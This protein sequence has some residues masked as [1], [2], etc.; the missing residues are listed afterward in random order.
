M[1]CE[2]FQGLHFTFRLVRYD[3]KYINAMRICMQVRVQEQGTPQ[4]LGSRENNDIRSE[5]QVLL[6]CPDK[7]YNSQTDNDL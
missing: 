3:Y 1:L 7:R 6:V 2:T 4:M 5:I